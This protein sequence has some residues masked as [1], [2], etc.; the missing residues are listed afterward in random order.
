MEL[1]AAKSLSYNAEKGYQRVK[2]TK[3]VGWR[4]GL[5]GVIFSREMAF[6]KNKIK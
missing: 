1:S 4:I 6:V 2:E 5:A 3:G